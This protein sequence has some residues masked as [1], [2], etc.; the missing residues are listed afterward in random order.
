MALLLFACCGVPTMV[1]LFSADIDTSPTGNTSTTSKAAERVEEVEI[2]TENT[3]KAG[4]SE[5][6]TSPAPEFTLDQLQDFTNQVDTLERLAS[7]SAEALSTLDDR[8]A[9]IFQANVSGEL[10]SLASPEANSGIAR[11]LRDGAAALADAI[12][13]R[14]ASAIDS[15]RRHVAAA[16]QLISDAMGPAQEQHRRDIEAKRKADETARQRR[17]EKA[18]RDAAARKELIGKHFSVWDGSHEALT[19]A[20]KA[21][22]HNPDSYDHVETVYWDRGDH[23]TVK[24]TYRGT[25][26]FGGIVTNWVTADVTL[27]GKI[28]DVVD[29]GP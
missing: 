17:A 19:K 11:E 2:D 24:T 10:E 13:R 15:A 1:G 3:I 22:M 25:N 12:Q 21:S 8:G 6:P 14:D 7:Q 26:A 5:A 28:I 29:Q 4:D 18:E 16:R 9:G 23:L 20:I 27:D